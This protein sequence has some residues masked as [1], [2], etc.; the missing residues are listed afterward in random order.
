MSST[1]R[2]HPSYGGHINE[3]RAAEGILI[4]VCRAVDMALNSLFEGVDIGMLEDYSRFGNLEI[5]KRVVQPST[6][7]SSLCPK[8]EKQFPAQSVDLNK[9]R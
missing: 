2:S 9:R 5:L 1:F 3:A 7:V 6:C 4:E 8:L